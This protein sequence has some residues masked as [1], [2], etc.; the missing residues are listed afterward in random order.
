M[1]T[2]PGPLHRRGEV[3]WCPLVGEN[4]SYQAVSRSVKGSGK[5]IVMSSCGANY[6][7]RTS[8]SGRCVHFG[9]RGVAFGCGVRVD[10]LL[11]LSIATAA[12]QR[13]EADAD[14]LTDVIGCTRDMSAIGVWS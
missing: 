11:H 10:C 1:Q 3:R 8:V 9:R 14:K 12:V 5:V 6:V 4:M 2:P 7:C 13:V